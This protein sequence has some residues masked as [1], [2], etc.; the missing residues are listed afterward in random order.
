MTLLAMAAIA[1][2]VLSLIAVWRAKGLWKLVATLPILGA[3]AVGLNIVLATSR[4][5]TSHNLW[6]L[7]VVLWSGVGIVFSIAFI[8]LRKAFSPPKQ[9]S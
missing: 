6:P 7:E 3:L 9:Q 5:P 8:V 4:D 2:A 1:N